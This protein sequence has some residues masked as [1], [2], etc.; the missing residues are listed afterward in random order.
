[1]Y[2]LLLASR[3]LKPRK[4]KET[5][6]QM[7]SDSVIMFPR[8]QPPRP[9]SPVGSIEFN[10]TQRAYSKFGKKKK[11]IIDAKSK[12]GGPFVSSS[13]TEFFFS[14]LFSPFHHVASPLIRALT[15]TSPYSVQYMITHHTLHSTL[16]PYPTLP[17]SRAT[18]PQPIVA[19]RAAYLRTVTT[20]HCMAPSAPT[21]APCPIT[22]HPTGKCGSQAARTR[23]TVWAAATK[24]APDSRP[25]LTHPP[26]TSSLVPATRR[27]RPSSSC[28]RAI[29]ISLISHQPTCLTK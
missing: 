5:E 15:Y 23:G 14:S 24:G 28:L 17:T 9:P 22:V 8:G 12:T 10:T 26:P 21:H 29:K 16:V 18:T 3:S 4:E 11:S 13:E 27:C 2:I 7:R 1:M 6:R 19:S 25:W 20:P